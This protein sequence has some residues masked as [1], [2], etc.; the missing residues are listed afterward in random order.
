MSL[1]PKID[2]DMLFLKQED[3]NIDDNDIVDHKI[4]ISSKVFLVWTSKVSAPIMDT[5][6]IEECAR[7]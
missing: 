2:A 5:L 4:V 3:L 1:M 7:V 6:S